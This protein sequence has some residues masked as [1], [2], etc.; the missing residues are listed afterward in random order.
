MMKIPLPTCQKCFQDFQEAL[1]ELRQLIMDFKYSKSD[2]KTQHK[3][4]RAFE[5]THELALRT[6]GEYFRK[7]G[8]PPF[9]GSRDATVEAF[10]EDLIDNG[11][12][13]LDMIIERIKFNP[14]YPEDYE[15]E[16]TQNIITKHVSLL[17]NFE[18][19][20]SKK[21]NQ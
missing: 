19:K 15:Y 14:L 7:E 2:A 17:E 6:I 12:G 13:W 10:H 11:K 18:R 5:L 1:D 16:F 3:I 21:L 8:R 20:L 4:I 9:S